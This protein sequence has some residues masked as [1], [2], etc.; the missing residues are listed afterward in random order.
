MV[1]KVLNF[2]SDYIASRN[3]TAKL[4]LRFSGNAVSP[5]VQSY[6][7]DLFFNQRTEIFSTFK[8][9]IMV[10]KAWIHRSQFSSRV[11]KCML[12]SINL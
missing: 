11:V 5:Q 3:C 10:S 12:L 1:Y 4:S 6:E 7:V 2:L 8:I 9:G